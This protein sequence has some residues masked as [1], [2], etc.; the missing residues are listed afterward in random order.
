MLD[1][2]LRGIIG[3][4]VAILI[5]HFLFPLFGFSG[6][7]L[8]LLNLLVLAMTLWFIGWGPSLTGK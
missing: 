6:D 2:I 8:L 3:I 4:I 1:Y 5:V 7:L